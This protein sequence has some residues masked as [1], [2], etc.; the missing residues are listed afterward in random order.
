MWAR[1]PGFTTLVRIIIEQQVSLVS[2]RAMFERLKTNVEPFAAERFIEV[3]EPFLRS[4]GMTR[5]K[6]AYCLH[7]AQAIT[8]GRL[9]SL[10]RLSD[11]DAHATLLH[12]K[13]IGPWTAQVYLLMA[14]R[15]P[16]IWPN[17]DVAL[18]SAVTNLKQLKVRPS[19]PELAQMADAWRPFR[20][21]AAR[22]LWQYYL[23]GLQARRV[24]ALKRRQ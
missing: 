20:S 10:S 21:V 14:L 3:G 15:R 12:I 7:L 19:F 11:D 1:K 2:A 18:A 6:S 23:A 8:E 22:M 4:L 13:G 5:Q 24:E 9:D 17:G 16:D